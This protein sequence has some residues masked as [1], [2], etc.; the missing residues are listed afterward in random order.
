MLSVITVVTNCA[1][2]STNKHMRAFFPDYSDELWVIFWLV[3]EHFLLAVQYVVKHLFSKV[4]YKVKVALAAVDY[5][6][7]QA[8]KR[9]VIF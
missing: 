1:V 6:S 8:L 4:P 7:R 5:R 9:E 2:L 3:V